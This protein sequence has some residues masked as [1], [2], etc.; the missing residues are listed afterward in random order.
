MNAVGLRE[1]PRLGISL[2]ASGMT[3]TQLVQTQPQVFTA[4]RSERQVV[5]SND[6][7]GGNRVARLTSLR[8]ETWYKAKWEWISLHN[9]SNS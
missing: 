7:D 1:I 4:K 9:K 8:T 5:A 6:N 2:C 3:L